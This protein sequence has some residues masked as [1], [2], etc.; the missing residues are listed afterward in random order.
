MQI[1]NLNTEF[2]G[3]SLNTISSYTY[4]LSGYSLSSHIYWN[5][6]PLIRVSHKKTKLIVVKEGIVI[7][8]RNNRMKHARFILILSIA[9]CTVALSVA[10]ASAEEPY[11]NWSKQYNGT[12]LSS[13]TATSVCM[14]PDGSCVI[15]GAAQIDDNYPDLRF[16]GE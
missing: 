4:Y 6:P 1:S 9:L 2:R 8:P 13:T 7:I 16:L 12:G 3:L 10:V 15:V 11:V 14:T 5:N